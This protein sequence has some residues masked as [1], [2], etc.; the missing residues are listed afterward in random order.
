MLTMCYSGPGLEPQ[1]PE[2]LGKPLPGTGRT[3]QHLRT[4]SGSNWQQIKAHSAQMSVPCSASGLGSGVPMLT[5]TVAHLLTRRTPAGI[6][7]TLPPLSEREPQGL[8]QGKG[9][10]S[11]TATSGQCLLTVGVLG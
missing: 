6:Q 11:G 8:L 9:L 2:L 4:V 10:Y 5:A 7:S 1:P 3:L